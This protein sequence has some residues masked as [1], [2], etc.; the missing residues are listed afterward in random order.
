MRKS[1]LISGVILALCMTTAS[2]KRL[3]DSDHF[4]EMELPADSF[5]I[6]VKNKDTDTVRVK[7]CDNI[8]PG[9]HCFEYEMMTENGYA[10]YTT[11]RQFVTD[12][13]YVEGK[14]SSPLYKTET[15]GTKV[16]TRSGYINIEHKVLEHVDKRELNGTISETPIF[17]EY[18][19]RVSSENGETIM[20]NRSQLRK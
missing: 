18:S 7:L 20:N 10:S 5:V 11:S 9:S 15:F 12:V 14:L 16:Y 6:T 3:D 1:R 4:V 17:A 13:S 2:A 8:N 19:L